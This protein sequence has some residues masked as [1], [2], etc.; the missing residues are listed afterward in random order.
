MPDQPITY[1]Q[2]S[3][4]DY[5]ECPLRYK[6]RYLDEMAWPAARTDDQLQN[7]HHTQQGVEFHRL[8]QQ[9]IV[10]IPVDILQASIRD[11]LVLEWWQAFMSAR[12]AFPVS[13][14]EQAGRIRMAEHTITGQLAG[15]HLVAKVDLLVV[16]PGEKIWIFDWKTGNKPLRY[17]HLLDRIQTR[18]Y[19]YMS[20]EAGT[21][22]NNGQ[23]FPADQVEMIYWQAADP[24]ELIRIP[25]STERF[26]Q[27]QDQLTRLIET[28]E[29]EPEDGFF[30]TAEERNCRF[31]NYRSFCERGFIPGSQE[32]FEQSAGGDIDLSDVELVE[33]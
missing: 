18:V 31:C 29:G 28:I 30:R 27:D 6:L 32:E 11:P 9:F 15:Q 14:D 10:G 7:E 1:S 22:W 17:S 33:Y 23:P 24:H 12:Q 4:Q 8:V 5:I 26:Q 21:R 13:I 25:Y 20:V 3:L 19:M 16:Q 2:H